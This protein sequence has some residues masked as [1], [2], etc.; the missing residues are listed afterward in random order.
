LVNKK[1][2]TGVIKTFIL[3]KRNGFG[4]RLISGGFIRG[5]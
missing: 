3:F 4:F 1:Y 2:Y 5:C